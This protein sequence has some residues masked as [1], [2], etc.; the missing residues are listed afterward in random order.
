LKKLKG[1]DREDH[2]EALDPS[3]LDPTPSYNLAIF[4][5]VTLPLQQRYFKEAIKKC[6]VLID[7]IILLKI[8]WVQSQ[9][10]ESFDSMVDM[11]L[12]AIVCHLYFTGKIYFR[13]SSLNGFNVCL[14]FLSNELKLGEYSAP[15]L[16]DDS[17][18]SDEFNKTIHDAA[19][20]E[21]FKFGI[22]LSVSVGGGAKEEEKIT[23]YNL[24]WRISSNALRAINLS[25]KNSR[26]LLGKIIST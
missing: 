15:F 7:T 12:I 3:Q 25:A 1:P 24:L 2:Q 26:K 23:F 16:K 18:S 11:H 8:W 17:S 20:A 4:E 6:P 10:Y 22:H 9:P 14:Q 5:D 21:Y 19:A 13:M